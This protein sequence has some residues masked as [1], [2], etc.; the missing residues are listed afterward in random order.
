MYTVGTWIK[1]Y[2]HKI[3]KQ[4]LGL[5]QDT[6]SNFELLVKVP[7][8]FF[9]SSH[10][11]QS[12]LNGELD[13][14][15]NYHQP[16]INKLKPLIGKKEIKL[17]DLIGTRILTSAGGYANG[18]VQAAFTGQSKKRTAIEEW[19][20]KSDVSSAYGFGL[21]G[22]DYS[23]SNGRNTYIYPTKLGEKAVT[24]H[25]KQG[26]SALKTF[27]I[28]NCLF[29]YPIIAKVMRFANDW[30]NGYRGKDGRL[31]AHKYGF[32]KFDLGE[33]LGFYDDG[34]FISYPYDE[35][36][37]HYAKA[38]DGKDIVKQTRG[39]NIGKLVNRTPSEVK[40]NVESTSDKYIRYLTKALSPE[41]LKVYSPDGKKSHS[42]YRKYKALNGHE[43]TINVGPSYKLGPMGKLGVTYSNSTPKYVHIELLGSKVNEISKIR[44][45]L[46]I[47]ILDKGNH[48][49]ASKISK[50]INLIFP[51]AK[52]TA[53]DVSDDLDGLNRIGIRTKYN[54]YKNVWSLQ[55][56]VIPFEIPIKENDKYLP[57]KDQIM[58]QFIRPRL[59]KVPH[60]LLM[61]L[62]IA[63]KKSTSNAEDS[64]LEEYSTEMFNQKGLGYHGRHLGRTGE[65]EPDGYATDGKTSWIIDSKAYSSGY[66]VD[67][68][69]AYEMIDYMHQLDRRDATK[70]NGWW[71]PIPDNGRDNQ[72]YVYVSGYFKNNSLKGNKKLETRTG[73]EGGLLAYG[74]LLLIAED[75]REQKISRAQANQYILD[76]Q[77]NFEEYAKQL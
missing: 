52:S 72:H 28:R 19:A 57:S 39:K 13:K 51:E 63:F 29:G 25:D 56:K 73:H 22:I 30:E 24:V 6:N 8:L 75:Y 44:R 69:S 16:I 18:L 58:K 71:K 2:D 12:L 32:S 21:I 67:I 49:N 27:F 45:A 41:F 38:I 35:Y 77:I 17:H 64:T 31:H 36:A 47:E 48:L 5:G 23:K 11:S 61:G 33:A 50:K 15:T 68:S 7:A 40:S 55:D 62:D 34:G 74:K 1:K 54:K 65:H 4:A 37:A 70:D 3:P 66:H 42:G 60:Y 14:A 9:K 20:A 10:L 59:H 76:D 46:I 26:N 43:Y 53:A